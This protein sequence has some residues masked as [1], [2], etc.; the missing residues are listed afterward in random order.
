ME[1]RGSKTE[2]NL[3]DAF[4]GEATARSKYTYYAAMARNEGYEQIGDFFEQTAKNERE[5]AK[6]WFKLLHDGII[7]S[8]TVNLEDAAGGELY[9]WS[10]MYKGFAEDAQAEGFTEIARLFSGVAAI[11]KHHEER[12]SALLENIRGQQVFQRQEKQ[13]WICSNCGHI[14]EGAGAPNKCPVCSHPQ[15]YFEIRATNY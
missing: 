12:F 10:E 7:P 4:T 15:A 3:M 6:I 1:L 2:K 11:E 5:H 13:T 14:H 8:T 9:E